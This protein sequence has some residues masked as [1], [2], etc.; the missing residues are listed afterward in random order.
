MSATRSI[1]GVAAARIGARSAGPS[2]PRWVNRRDTT[3][4]PR[5]GSGRFGSGGSR[6]SATDVVVSSGSVGAHSRQVCSTVGGVARPRRRSAPPWNP[7]T[8]TSS[9]VISVT[10]PKPPLP[11]RTAQ[12]RSTSSGSVLS[13]CDVADDAVGGDDR[14]PG[15]VVGGEAVAAGHRAEAAT[16]RVADHADLRRRAVQRRE[17]VRGGGVDDRTPPHPG[18]DA[19]GAG[20]RVDGDVGHPAGG[21]EHAAV[22]VGDEPVSGGLDGD[23]HAVVGGVADR[24]R[25][26]GGARRA[27]D[28]SGRRGSRPG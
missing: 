20:D 1:R 4:R 24:D 21:D 17:P 16:R 3:N 10:I 11:P 27:D 13:A 7:A 9:N 2:T 6:S 8:S 23:A 26:V 15:D 14:E 12:N 22:E 28:D 19:G 18:L 25:D 5:N